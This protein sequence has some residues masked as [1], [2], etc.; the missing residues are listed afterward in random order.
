MIVQRCE[1]DILR[2]EPFTNYML[3]PMSII[4][5]CTAGLSKVYADTFDGLHS[6]LIDAI[7]EGDLSIDKPMHIFDRGSRNSKILSLILRTR[8]SDV[9]SSDVLMERLSHV[10]SELNLHPKRSIVMPVIGTTYGIDGYKDALP[11][12]YELFDPLE[13][14]V[15][16]SMIPSYFSSAPKYLGVIGSRSL[17][18][19]EWYAETRKII[20][21]ALSSWSMSFSDFVAGISGGA[22]GVDAHAAGKSSGDTCI[23]KDVNL[24]NIVYHANWDEF[25]KSAGFI[26]NRSVIDIATHVVA[27]VDK[28][29]TPSIGTVM[30]VGLVKVWN[31]Q[32]P[33]N[34]KL[35]YVHEVV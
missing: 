2:L 17:I 10:V 34:P 32:F 15:Q 24:R 33:D 5:C 7:Y 29:N 18:G 8:S 23:F 16:L 19:E 20:D 26:R 6:A 11:M 25:G 13:N 14:I 4:G 30:V 27:I 22:N 12:M 9:I 31:S 35:L 21:A 28:R 1:S 3:H